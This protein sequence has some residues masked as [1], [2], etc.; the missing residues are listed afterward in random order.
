[1][2]KPLHGK[3]LR[4]ALGPAQWAALRQ[5]ILTE[6]SNECSVCGVT[7]THKAALHLH[8]EWEYDATVRPAVSRLSSLT[9]TCADCHAVEHLANAVLRATAADEQAQWLRL[10]TQFCRVNGVGPKESE[11]RQRIAFMVW[12]ARSALSWR[13]DLGEFDSMLSAAH[14]VLLELGEP[15]N[16]EQLEEEAFEN[17]V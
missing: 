12:T 11:V 14:C 2:P 7:P 5:R 6:A 16:F 3:N 4:L 17:G 10:Q 15:V 13:I 1:M 9:L 8:E